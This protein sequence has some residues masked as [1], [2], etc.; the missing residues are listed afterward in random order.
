MRRAILLMILM[1]AATTA[2]AHKLKVFATVEDGALAG[3][4]FFVGGGRP[5]GATF[6]IQDASG[7]EI[8][9]GTTDD[10]G[11]YSWQPPQPDDLKII[12]NAGDGHVADTEI[13]RDRFSGTDSTGGE[14]AQQSVSTPNGSSVTTTQEAE[15]GA[16]TLNDIEK[17]VDNSVERQIRPLLE[18]YA[19]AGDR[20]KLT[21]VVGGIGMIFGLAGIGMWGFSR[22][23]VNSP[24]REL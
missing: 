13:S 16:C 10:K 18:A 12:V 2:S 9:R 8:Y 21:D 6:I 17:V 3:Y 14:T 4:A 20:A 7:K 22:K 23:R 1:F 24:G 15:S 19:E 11:T 5:Q